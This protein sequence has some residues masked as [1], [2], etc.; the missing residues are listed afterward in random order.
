MK[1]VWPNG[2]A[3]E[4]RHRDMCRVFILG[5]VEALALAGF[6]EIVDAL[7]TSPTIEVSKEPDWSPGLEWVWW[8]DD[9]NGFAKPSI[10]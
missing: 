10:N 5:Y 6:D 3:N 1:V 7:L 2:A 9:S 4:K 8:D